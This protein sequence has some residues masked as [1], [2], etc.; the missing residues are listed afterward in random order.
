MNMF[1]QVAKFN[2]TMKLEIGLVGPLPPPYGGMA[3]QT[4]QLFSL[5]EMENVN[6]S[7][8][9]TNPPYPFQ[10]I[11]KITGVRAIFRL[12][13]YLIRLWNLAKR[14]DCLHVMANSGWSWQ[15]F[16]APVIW[17]GWLKNVPVIVNYRGGEAE[18]YLSY[19]IRWI[20]PTLKKASVLVVPSDYLKNVFEKFGFS[21]TVIPNIID[22]KKFKYN[23]RVCVQNKNKPMLVVARNLEAIYGINMAIKAI[24]IVKEE[25]PGVKLYIAGNGPLEESLK[26]QVHELNISDNVEFTG[27]L[28]PDEVSKLYSVVD[29]MLN[30]TTVD[31]MPNSIL[32][33]LACGIP[34]I[35][36]NVGG[37]PYIVS[38]Y[39]TALMVEVNN[40]QMMAD[41]VTQLIND[42]NLYEKLVI[43]GIKQIEK[44]TW[45]IVKEQWIGLYET[46]AVR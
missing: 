36:T 33:G 14:T 23:Y 34:V 44:Y 24:S 2:R 4:K 30:P 11:E 41:K 1:M 29:I 7:L 40:Y 20:E 6:V 31:N 37:I 21:A 5:L 13:P 16:A 27:R 26:Q 18:K 8:V 3:N 45:D 35:T 39:E 28:S 12:F 38:D 43:N 9:Q 42:D 25:I 19:S 15:L 17:I 22:L 32:E 10:F 46:L